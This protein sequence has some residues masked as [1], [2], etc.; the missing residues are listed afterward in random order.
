MS[1]KTPK[2]R[3]APLWLVA[4][5]IASSTA[6]ALTA[7]EQLGKSIFFD[8]NLSINKNQ[9]CASCHGPEVGW[10][11]PDQHINVAGTVYEGS[12][13]GRFGDRKPPSSAYA[14]FSPIFHLQRQGKD[15][16]FVGGNFWDG[17]ATGESWAI[18]PPIKR[19]GRFST[20]SSKPCRM[21]P[22]WCIGSA[23]PVIGLA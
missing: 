8:Q 11:G 7:E 15:A 23:T 12:I 20:R 10:T 18:P 5:A 3:L 19:K 21:P 1:K 14:T 16:L 4:I 2:R 22:A 17:R 9:S 6:H 13:L